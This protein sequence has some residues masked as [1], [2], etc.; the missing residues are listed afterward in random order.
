MEGQGRIENEN[1]TLSTERCVNIAT[2]H[3]N[4]RNLQVLNANDY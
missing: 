4:K 3:I 2:M 1:K